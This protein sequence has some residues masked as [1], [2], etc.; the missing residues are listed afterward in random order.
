MLC[1]S[2]GVSSR[3]IAP[4][5]HEV[6]NLFAYVIIQP[7]AAAEAGAGRDKVSHVINTR[8]YGKLPNRFT[9]SSW[10]R[11]SSIIKSHLL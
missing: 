4:C 9:Q 1:I 10:M 3:L 6:H 11:T 7:H 2:E 8:V 5:C